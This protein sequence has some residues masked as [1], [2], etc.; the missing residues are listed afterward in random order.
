M[1]L[2]SL[3]RALLNAREHERP[4][5]AREL[6]GHLRHASDKD[7]V[8]ALLEVARVLPESLWS[9]A[10]R[11][12]EAMAPPEAARLLA[13]IAPRIPDEQ[14]ERVLEIAAR[15][16]PP[17]LRLVVEALAPYLALHLQPVA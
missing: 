11:V 5:L 15:L 13:A 17:F 7:V 16:P 2:F 14:H 4:E 1:D 3:R 8:A 9:E 6:L 10:L 12:V